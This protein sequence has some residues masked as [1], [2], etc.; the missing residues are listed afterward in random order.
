MIG[1]QKVYWEG[2]TALV[3]GASSGIG[4]S[5]ARLLA[6]HGLRV[7]LTA[8]RE[9]RLLSLQAEIIRAGGR[10]EVLPGDLSDPQDRQRLME[11][12][13]SEYPVVD[14]LINNAGL[15]WYGY[16]TD[17]SVEL[18]RQMLQV[19]VAAMVELSMQLLPGMVARG[20]GRI[21]NIS[22]ISAAIPSQGIAIYGA[23]KS[24]IDSFSTALH[25]E[26]SGSKVAVTTIRPGPVKSEFYELAAMQAGGK[27]IPAERFSISSERVAKAVWQALQSPRRVVN[28]PWYLG[29]VPW[30]E[31]L[32][33]WII[34][35][36][37]P[38]L[39]QR[40][41]QTSKF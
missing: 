19:N 32:F 15:G 11:R 35:R 39:L 27:R 14:V 38:V 37:G 26:L 8:R 40:K 31:I 4:A 30:V 3:T 21:I 33:G 20:Q 9:D 25:R 34:D 29:I 2:K 36:V 1:K 22:S 6:A 24:F 5:T 41:A 10:A 16:L 7:I 17:M 28:V 23:T 13:S 18:A 12:L